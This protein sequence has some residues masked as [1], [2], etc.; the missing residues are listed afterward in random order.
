MTRVRVS[1]D[2]GSTLLLTIF[3]SALTLTVILMGVAATSLYLEQKR[4]FD[5]AD[6]AALVG[7]ESFDIAS[8]SLTGDGPRPGLRSSQISAAVNEY[9]AD[10]ARGNFAGLAV[11]HAGTPDGLSARVTL[12]AYWRP[13]VLN[14]L[15]PDGFRIEA[16]TVA[17]AV[18]R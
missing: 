8:I 10:N 4:L 3:F 9:V 12:S 5:L 13:P 15:A 1:D 17:R 7:A 11:E 14:L 18:F 6:G 2:D 16:S